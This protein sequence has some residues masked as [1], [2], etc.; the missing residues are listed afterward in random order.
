[1]VKGSVWEKSRVQSF[2]RWPSGP[3]RLAPRTLAPRQRLQ[4]CLSAI[5]GFHEARLDD[6][7]AFYTSRAPLPGPSRICANPVA[8]LLEWQDAL[9][10]LHHSQAVLTPQTILTGRGQEAALAP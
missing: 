8:T 4:A 9:V 2:D 1:M 5:H 10:S 6:E 3:R 7:C